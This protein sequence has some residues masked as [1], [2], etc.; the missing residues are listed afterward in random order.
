LRISSNFLKG[1]GHSIPTFSGQ[2]RPAE[3]RHI[4]YGKGWS[5]IPGLHREGERRAN[6]GEIY[7]IL[8]LPIKEV[9]GAKVYILS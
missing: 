4:N 2:R 7:P 3:L 9:T 5:D 8:N 1:R 6:L